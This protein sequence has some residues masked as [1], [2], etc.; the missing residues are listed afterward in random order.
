MTPVLRTT[1]LVLSLALAATA[2]AQTTATTGPETQTPRRETRTAYEIRNQFSNLLREHPRDLWTILA[3]DP[4]LLANEQFMAN[5][6]DLEKFVAGA[7]EMRANPKFYLVEFRA[8]TD[9]AFLIDEILELFFL[10]GLWIMVVG[11]LVWIIRTVIE[12]K[13]WNRLSARQTDVHNRILERFG[14]SE[15][16]LEYVKT[17]AGSKYLEAAPIAVSVEKSRAPLT[18][19][20]WSIQLGVVVAIGAMGMLIVGLRFEGETSEALFVIGA[21]GFC[22]GLGFIASAA[23]SLFLSRRLGLWELPPAPNEGEGVR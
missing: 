12:Q 9:S 13:R 16:L 18:R 11:G 4:T 2:A 14:T 8:H 17:P 19:I 6:P 20:M 1:I 7:P 22:V 15:E 21:I 10:T 3:L 23:V 5:Y